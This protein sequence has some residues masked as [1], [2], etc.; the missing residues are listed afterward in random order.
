MTLTHEN[1][2]Q[3][4]IDWFQ[5][6]LKE[7]AGICWGIALNGDRNIIGTIGFNNFTPNHRANTGFDL[8][9]EFWNQGLITEALEAANDFGFDTLVINSIEAEVM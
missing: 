6:R 1:D 3:K 7:K 9:T 2:G 4:L 5:N 8:R